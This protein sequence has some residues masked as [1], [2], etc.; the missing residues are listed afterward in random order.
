MRKL[1]AL[2]V[3]HDLDD[4]ILDNHVGYDILRQVQEQPISSTLS[5]RWAEDCVIG[6]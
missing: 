5:I 3:F 2:I 4:T 6:V 1:I